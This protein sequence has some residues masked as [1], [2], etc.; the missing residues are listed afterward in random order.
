[1]LLAT[2]AAA[3][4]AVATPLA[5]QAQDAEARR[6]VAIERETMS[7]FCP[8]MTLYTCPSPA[9]GEWRRDIRQWVDEGLGEREIRARLQARVPDFDLSGRPA[10]DR[11]WTLPVAAGVLATLL[12]VVV[13][14]RV[15][16]RGGDPE[17]P[18]EAGRGPDDLDA[19]LDR[20]L[21]A[22]E[23]V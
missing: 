13:A 6:A 19:R 2:L 4:L 10:G 12:L 15:R 9:A 3:A 8:G 18:E 1:M 11:S 5:V 17:P 20:E 22:L 21:E 16:R 7:P 23:E 14:V